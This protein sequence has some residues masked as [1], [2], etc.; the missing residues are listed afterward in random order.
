MLEI[1]QIVDDASPLLVDVKELMD[2]IGKDTASNHNVIHEI[3]NFTGQALW[4]TTVG[5]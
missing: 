3:Y 5:V 4:E 1:S 2:S